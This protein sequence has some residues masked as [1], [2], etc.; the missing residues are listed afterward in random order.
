M[1]F[2]VRHDESRC[3]IFLKFQLNVGQ[4]CFNPRLLLD[5]VQSAT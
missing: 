4:M 2:G 3:S 5:L 1:L